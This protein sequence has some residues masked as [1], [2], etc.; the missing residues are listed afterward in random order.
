MPDVQIPGKAVSD[1]KD[2]R[3]PTRELLEDLY[4]LG[5][6]DDYAKS[7][8]FSSLF[9]GPPESV[10]VIEAGATTATKWW[11]AGLGAAVLLL[12]G[13]V[14]KWWP[15]EHDG[16]RAVVVGSTAL[17]TSVVAVAISYLFASDVRGRAAATVSTIEARTQL[18]IEMI[19][20]AQ[21]VYKPAAAEEPA[22]QLVPLPAGVKVRNSSVPSE[23]E[24]GWRAV[25]IQIQNGKHKYVVVKGNSE[26]LLEADDLNF[27]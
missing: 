6:K 23:N 8:S 26:D 24:K 9:T 20:A 12:W 3:Q 22:A 13:Y 7:G 19:K 14:R 15:N 10:S 4:L 16:I 27:G 18:A 2:V 25:A 17:V 5:T 21:G 11:A 1:E